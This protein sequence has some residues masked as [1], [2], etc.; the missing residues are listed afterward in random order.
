MSNN[1]GYARVSTTDQSADLQVDALTLPDWARIFIEDAS[2]ATTDRLALISR[3][4]YLN[5]G[6]ILL[7]WCTDRPWRP[8]AGVGSDA[9]TP[10]RAD[11]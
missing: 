6:D 11:G 9:G 7:V 4:E 10:T 2:G 5:P 8:T 1:I 3:L